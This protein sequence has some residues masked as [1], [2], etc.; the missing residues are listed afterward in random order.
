LE[1]KKKA[2]VSKLK[3]PL[4]DDMVTTKRFLGVSP[5]QFV[6]GVEAIFPSQMALPV[7][8]LFQDYQ[9]EPDDMI[10]RIQQ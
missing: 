10:R 8:K 3:F 1:D 6:Y 4:W 7:E 2:W 5:F 9:G